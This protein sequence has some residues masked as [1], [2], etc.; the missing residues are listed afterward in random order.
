MKTFLL[1]IWLAAAAFAETKHI[2]A[3]L[4]VDQCDVVGVYLQTTSDASVRAYVKAKIA[5]I[6]CV[7]LEG[8]NETYRIA[9]NESLAFTIIGRAAGQWFVSARRLSFQFGETDTAQEGDDVAEH[10]IKRGLAF[11]LPLPLAQN[12]LLD[13][14]SATR[15]HSAQQEAKNRKAGIWHYGEN[16]DPFAGLI[17]QRPQRPNNPP[18]PKMPPRARKSNTGR[19]K[20]KN[21]P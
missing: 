19:F 7:D 13:V 16:V 12:E 1:M 21:Q 11:A 3:V 5:G 14:V 10:L 8:R 15:Y 2:A 4:D 20:S 17:F 6:R 18:R 9:Q